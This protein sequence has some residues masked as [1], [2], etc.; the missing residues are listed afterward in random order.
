[1][2]FLRIIL[3]AF[4]G[5]QANML[6]SLL[7]TLGV[8]IGVGAVISAMSILEG[9]QRD[10]LQK[11][12]SLGSNQLYVVPGQARRAGRGMGSVQTLQM[13]DVD[14]LIREADSVAAAAPEFYLKAQVKWYS[15]N[16]SIDVFGTNEYYASMNNYRTQAGEFISAEDVRAE[17]RVV[18]L[19]YRIAK[20][21][22][23]EAAAIGQTLRIGIPGGR[24]SSFRVIGVMEKKG[25]LG[26]RTVDEQVFVPI[27]T[28]MKRL[29]GINYIMAITVQAA[30]PDKVEFCRQEIK[31]VL[32]KQ[33]NT[34]TGREEDFQVFSQEEQ[35]R[36]VQE[37]VTLFAMVF[38]SIAGISL[39]VGGIGIMNIML[40]SVTERTR[41]IGVR[42]AVGA[43][44]G[45]ILWQ[46]LIE[47]GSISVL[48]GGFGVLL[49]FVMSSVMENVSRDVLETYTPPKVIVW[50]LM[51]AMLTGILSGLYPAYKASRLDPVE[52]LR[53]E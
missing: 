49:G 37:T 45:D 32:R 18:C 6:R 42:I 24:S 22:F 52:A 1:M 9:A 40:V 36:I 25:T 20:D 35:L 10:V 23:G 53:Y 31:K 38:Y 50:A 4:R 19:G 21:L 30:D 15:K 41:E 12:E 27:T 5:L 2:F 28:A 29:F 47:A 3:M 14:A 44:R 43:Q 33:H 11:I 13:E 26:F 8:I 51:M 34:P 48:G 7:A 16:K 39:V 17:R 46:F